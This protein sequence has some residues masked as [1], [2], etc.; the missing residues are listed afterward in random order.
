MTMPT[1]HCPSLRMDVR[2]HFLRLFLSA[3]HRQAVFIAG[4]LPLDM[5]YFWSIHLSLKV[6]S[7]EI[8]FSLK[9]QTNKTKVINWCLK[10]PQVVFL[11]LDL[12]VQF[13][14]SQLSQGILDTHLKVPLI[15]IPLTT[16]QLLL[17]ISCFQIESLELCTI[18]IVRKYI[19]T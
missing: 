7:Q 12:S 1:D 14:Q 16:C 6:S 8:V 17:C 2:V 3:D 4:Q 9:Y 5:L 11:R 10:R 19:F 18:Y 15:C 13:N